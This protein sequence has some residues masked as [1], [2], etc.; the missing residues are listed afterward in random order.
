MN[1]FLEGS[2]A[3]PR[4]KGVTQYELVR[5]E[6]RG[7]SAVGWHNAS[8]ATKLNLNYTVLF[9]VLGT[10]QFLRDLLFSDIYNV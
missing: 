4:L 5:Y 3:I 1:P 9:L 7:G 2:V 6:G 10:A 8:T